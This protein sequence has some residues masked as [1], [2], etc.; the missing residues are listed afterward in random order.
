MVASLSVHDSEENWAV[1]YSFD[2]VLRGPAATPIE[3]R[4]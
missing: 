4:F 2:I 3:E 1:G